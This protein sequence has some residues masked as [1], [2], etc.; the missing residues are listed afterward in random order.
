[1][2]DGLSDTS[3]RIIRREF[4][5]FRAQCDAEPPICHIIDGMPSTRLTSYARAIRERHG[6]AIEGTG[7]IYSTDIEE[8][9][10]EAP[11][12]GVRIF[13]PFDE[14]DVTEAEFDAFMLKV[15][16]AWIAISARQY[17]DRERWWPEFIR[18]VEVIRARV[19]TRG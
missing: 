7:F 14:V 18:D 1:M 17:L 9:D 13:D 15:F 12:D 2:S 5:D 3:V 4:F 19:A 16:D 10:E 8:E 6:Y 11:L